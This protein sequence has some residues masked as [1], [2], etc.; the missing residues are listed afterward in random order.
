[1]SVDMSQRA[2]RPG[3]SSVPPHWRLATRMSPT[4]RAAIIFILP[5][6]IL[7][8][9]FVAWPVVEVFRMS[10]TDW[11]GAS[12][13]REFIGADNYRTLWDSPLFWRALRNNAVWMV[14]GTLAPIAIGLVLAMLLRDRPYGHGFLATV[15]FVPQILGAGAIGIAWGLIYRPRTGLLMQITQQLN[16]PFLQSSPV[17]NTSTVLWAILVAWTWSAVGFFFV[18]MLAGL[19]NVDADL[20]DAAKVDGASVVQRFVHVII[21]QLSHV[22]TLSIVLGIVAGMK[23]FDIIW[24]MTGGGPANASEVLATLGFRVF[25]MQ[26]DVGLASAVTTVLTVLALI[27]AVLFIYLRERQEAYAA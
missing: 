23:V 27:F 12:P 4:V 2:G 3:T 20:E 22:I 9:A 24:A 18:I 14:V 21:P 17:A 10:L 15:F 5:A 19:Q 25:L 16:L 1:M 11:D 13:T 26:S 6:L 8:V 7:Y